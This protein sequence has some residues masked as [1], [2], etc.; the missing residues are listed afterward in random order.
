MSA[1]RRTALLAAA[2]LAGGTVAA[3]LV[4]PA[5]AGAA[6]VPACGNHSLTVSAT[7]SDSASGHSRI[8]LLFRNT[9]HATCSLYGYPGLDALAA[10][11]QVL[12]HARRTLAGFMG[13]SRH[14]LRTIVIRPGGYGSAVVEWLNFNPV[15][16]GPCRYSHSVATT[17][18]NTTHTVRLA[19]SVSVCALQV[20]PTVAGTSGSG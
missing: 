4:A 5:G 7:R 17:P 9:T 1:P 13:G 10:N 6:P 3:A 20:H 19:R 8:V 2:A 16:T 14:G 18:P 15:T 11:G 12:A